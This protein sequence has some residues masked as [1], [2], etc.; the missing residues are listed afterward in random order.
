[1]KKKLFLVNDDMIRNTNNG[2]GI[3]IFDDYIL[4][5]RSPY[6]SDGMYESPILNYYILSSTREVTVLWDCFRNMGFFSNDPEEIYQNMIMYLQSD[7][8]EVAEELAELAEEAYQ[9]VGADGLLKA[10]VQYAFSE[11]SND[12]EFLRGVIKDAE[13]Q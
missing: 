6:S 3:A 1:M 13:N 4:L 9:K 11:E 2:N 12:E 7:E 10:M 5:S 8:R